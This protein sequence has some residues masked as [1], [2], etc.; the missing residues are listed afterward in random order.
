MPKRVNRDDIDKFH[1][2]KLYLPTRTIYMGSEYSDGENES[3][4]DALMAER[5]IKNIVILDA[6]SNDP[7]T[8][9]MNNIG[10]DE[11]HGMAIY[12]AIKS[13]HSHVTI[14]VFGQAFSMGSVILQAADRRVM[15]TTSQ[16]MAHYGTLSLEGH[17]KTVQKTLQACDKMNKWMERMY[18]ARIQEKNPD[19][20]KEQLKELLDHDTYLNASESIAMGLADEILSEKDKK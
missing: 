17:A 13:C 9:I 8:V 11:S 20:T 2:Y 15:S 4:V 14:K 10:G 5:F 12:D 7:I 6:M 1:D 18:L 19:Y 16:Q 3:G